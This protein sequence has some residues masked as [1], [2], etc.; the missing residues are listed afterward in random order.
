[1][2]NTKKTEREVANPLKPKFYKRFV[3]NI[4]EEE[5]IN[6]IR[7]LKSLTLTTLI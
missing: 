4:I 6:E 1:M 2:A 7:Y 5:K 3:D